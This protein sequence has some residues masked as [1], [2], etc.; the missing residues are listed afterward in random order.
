MSIKKNS[1]LIYLIDFLFLVITIIIVI[2]PF[3]NLNLKNFLLGSVLILMNVF[4]VVKVKNNKLYLLLVY[5]LSVINISLA[6]NDIILNGKNVSD[7]QY[8]GLRTSTINDKFSESIVLFNSIL[9]LF[10]KNNNMKKIS[11]IH[12]R[13]NNIVIFSIGSIIAFFILIYGYF[14]V[15]DMSGVTYVSIS[16]PLFEYS[17]L[18]WIFVWYYSKDYKSFK[19]IYIIYLILYIII[20]SLIGDRSSIFLY[21]IFG[22]ITLLYHHINIKNLLLL[23]LF[24]IFFSNLIATFRDSDF[25]IDLLYKSIE[26]GLYIDTVSYSYYTSLAISS[27][28]HVDINNIKYV[29][30]ILK[31]VFLNIDSEYVNLPEYAMSISPYLYNNYGGIIVGHFYSYGGY[32]SVILG[33]I[34]LGLLIKLIFNSNKRFMIIY[35][36]VFI[37]FSIRWYLYSPSVI[38]SVI[39]VNTTIVFVLCLLTD[40]LIRKIK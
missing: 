11:E 29:I 34:I 24:G 18:I 35:Q 15:R 21:L 39:I 28:Y 38:L 12:Y 27:L 40:Y 36:I 20:F 2:L 3:E 10:I 13:K 17:I 25:S 7:W 31:N 32:L 1:T 23:S 30:A 16:N 33:A 6:I 4:M 9:N 26:K 14:T 8:A 37:V 22:V 19:V 5:I